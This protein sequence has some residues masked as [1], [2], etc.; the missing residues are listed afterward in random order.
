MMVMVVNGNVK[1]AYSNFNP[2]LG[3]YSSKKGDAWWYQITVPT[4]R[5]FD[6]DFLDVHIMHMNGTPFFFFEILFDFRLSGSLYRFCILW[7]Q[8]DAFGS[9]GEQGHRRNRRA[10][11]LVQTAGPALR[12]ACG[13]APPRAFSNGLSGDWRA[14]LDFLCPVLMFLNWGRLSAAQDLA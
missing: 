4:F 6:Y 9:L 14:L 10:Q 8:E 1:P 7:S 11:A 2:S 3:S 12:G 5:C 13:E